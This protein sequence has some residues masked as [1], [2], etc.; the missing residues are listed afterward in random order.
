MSVDLSVI[1]ALSAALEANPDSLPVRFH[2]ASLL[3]ENKDFDK[4]LEHF[5]VIL[6][7]EPANLEA[8]KGAAAAAAGTGD[9]V[10]A[11][12]YQRL[13]TALDGTQPSSGSPASTVI[14]LPKSRPSTNQEKPVGSS[15][16]LPEDDDE[17]AASEPSRLKVIDASDRFF[18]ETED[19]QVTLADVGGMEVVKK[20]LHIAFLGPM[21][22]PEIRRMYGKSLRGGLL[23]YGPPGCGKTFI[24]RALA[25]ELGA[26]FLSIG[27]S[28]VL[29]MW[30]GESERKLHEMFETARRSKPCVLFFD[31]VDALGHKRSQLKGHG[32]RNVVVA[33][34]NEL[35]GLNH[36]N[37]GIFVL[38]ATNHPWDVDSALRRPG[39]FDRMV[40]VLPPDEKAREYILYNNLKD[41]PVD[42]QQVGDRF[43]GSVDLHWIAARTKEYSGAD[44]VHLCES[45]TEYA[46]E[47]SLMTGKVRP[48]TT[49]DFKRALRDLRP[50]IRAWF[51]TARNYAM[52]ANEGGMYDDL[53]AF[54]KANNY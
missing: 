23:L 3:V 18:T 29:D 12:G 53:L 54:I 2:L 28:D 27:I 35:D 16:D 14:S 7:R 33:L 40:L 45:A 10:R 49:D 8:L 4:A 36:N 13:L 30:L 52:F 39:R 42:L 11:E 15:R 1:L 26:R 38:G 46:M 50:S 34:L 37:E 19:P 43:V 6:S 22:N 51:D 24:A 47:E 41:R 31:E 17:E 21:K 5:L 25:G 9:H 32:G 48:L 20:R 44:L